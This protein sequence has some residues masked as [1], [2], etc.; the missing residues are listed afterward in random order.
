MTSFRRGTNT[1]R[2]R[3][4]LEDG[5]H[6]LKYKYTVCLSVIIRDRIS[7]FV[8]RWFVC[9]VPD[10]HFG[11]TTSGGCGMNINMFSVIVEYQHNLIPPRIS[12]PYSLVHQIKFKW[13]IRIAIIFPQQTK[14]INNHIF[15]LF[16][17][18]HVKLCACV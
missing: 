5:E 7:F 2:M 3:L 17:N 6:N 10:K 13:C 9:F 1:T 11:D 8:A 16:V 14:E 18:R 12:W 4:S 15:I